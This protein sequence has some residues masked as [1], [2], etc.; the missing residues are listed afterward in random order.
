MDIP[1]ALLTQVSEGR[2]VLLLGAGASV[3]ARTSEGKKAPSTNELRDILAR[4]FLGGKFLELP[5]NQVAELAISETDLP[6]VQGYIARVFEGLLPTPAHVQMGDLPWFGLGTT[7][8]DLLIE[9]GYEA[10][11]QALQTPMPLI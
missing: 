10:N 7:N 4:K 5:L 8:Y 11:K 9:R 6:T 1:E 3:D 2:V